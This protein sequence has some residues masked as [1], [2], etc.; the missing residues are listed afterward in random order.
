MA[1]NESATK[2]VV[3]CR[4]SFANI[5][6]AKSING[7][8]PKYSVSC[9][10]P[11]SDKK[12]LAKIN[13]A[14]E[15]AKEEAKGKKWGGK[16]PANLKLP[17]RDGDIERPD[18]ENYANCMFLNANSSDKPGIVDRQ[19]NPI[20]DPMQVYSGCYCNVSLSLYGFNSNGNRGVACGLGNIQWL[21]DGERL[22]GKA[23]AASDFEA[24]ADDADVLG[25][26]ELPDYL[27]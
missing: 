21:K 3:P 8:D 25:D 7:S 5:W 19:V 12:T 11:K 1:K 10:I 18:D 4:I 27:K 16:I 13:A 26:D 17:L 15:A 2:I 24:V 22:S 6:E 20:L 14:I 23:D 9:L